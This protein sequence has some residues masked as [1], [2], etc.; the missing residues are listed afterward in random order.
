MTLACILCIPFFPVLYITHTCTITQVYMWSDDNECGKVDDT[1]PAVGVL[2][3]FSRFC[4]LQ[5]FSEPQ[6]WLPINICQVSTRLSCGDT[7]QISTSFKESNRYFRSIK[8]T[9]TTEKLP[10]ER[11]FGM[12]TSSNGNIFRVTSHL[13]GN[14]PVP[15][16]SPHKG[17]WRGALMFTL[18]CARMYGWVNNR[19]AGDLRRYRAHY[20]VIVMGKPHP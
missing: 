1:Q 18:I 10:N 20:D 4:Y 11:S 15:V 12:M 9:V 3:Q 17:Q 6:C 16:N 7:W 2:N 5:V 19:E 14:S 8:F 13:C